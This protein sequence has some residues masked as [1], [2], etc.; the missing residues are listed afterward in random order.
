MI[1]AS[2]KNLQMAE[3]NNDKDWMLRYTFIVLNSN[4]NWEGKSILMKD[5]R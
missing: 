4:T 2:N 1:T 5:S 3:F